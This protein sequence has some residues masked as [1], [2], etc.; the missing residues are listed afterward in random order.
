MRR[1]ARRR[2]LAG[3]LAGLALAAAGCAGA[4]DSPEEQAKNAVPAPEW[5]VGDRWV[6]NRT[7]LGGAATVVTHQIVAETTDGFTMRVL[8]LAGDVRRQ[9]TRDLAIAE[10]TTSD[11]T[12]LRYTPPTPMFHWP[13]T[14]SATWTH[15]FTYTDGRQDGRYQNTWRVGPLVERIEV[16]AGRFYTLR[17]ERWS[18]TQRLEAY[19]YSALVRYWVR[20]EDYRRGF[21]EEL[22]EYGRWTGG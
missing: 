2:L 16:V 9:W 1:L 19:W 17:V 3:A 21:V 22:L 4:P 18:G 13:L 5:R 7:S 11:G 15:E 6:F 8:G 20:V 14:P 12:V 10:E